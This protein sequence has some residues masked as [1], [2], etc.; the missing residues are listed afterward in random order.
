MLGTTE[1]KKGFSKSWTNP[2]HMENLEKYITE[3]NENRL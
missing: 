2:I 3:E 1:F